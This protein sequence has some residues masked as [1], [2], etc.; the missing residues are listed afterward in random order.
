MMRFRS[1]AAAAVGVF[2]LLAACAAGGASWRAEALNKKETPPIART[3]ERLVDETG[4]DGV[5]LVAVNGA[6]ALKKGYGLADKSWGVPNAPDVR[7]QIASLSK[8]FT[9]ALALRL[10]EDGVFSLDATLNDLLPS[11]PAPYADEVTLRQLLL[12]TSGIPHYIDLPGWFDGAYL[13]PRP[14]EAFLDAIAA[15]PLKA[16]PGAQYRYSNA[17]YFLIGLVIERATGKPFETVLAEI[18]LEPL[19]LKDTG[20]FA[21]S[22]VIEKL[23]QNYIRNDDGLLEKAPPINADL[24]LATASLYSTVE[25]LF[26]WRRAL[27]EGDLLSA[28]SRAVMFDPAA[29]IGWTASR[30]DMNGD[31]RKSALWSYNGEI[32]GYTSMIV[33]APDANDVVILLSN[34]NAGFAALQRMSRSLLGAL[35]DARGA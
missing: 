8:A 12:H 25:D 29:P 30:V 23:A 18:I 20:H 28:E 10:A 17:N 3:V 24:F 21:N 31:G 15:L 33:F 27:F 14:T 19:G 4:F 16:E 11:Y 13:A 7:F 26:R 5:V 6:P 34:N 35:A 9:A 32:N 2:L 22:A 1:K